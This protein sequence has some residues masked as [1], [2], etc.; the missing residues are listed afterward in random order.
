MLKIA[1]GIG[2]L[3]I[4]LYTGFTNFPLWIVP[5]LGL[6]SAAAY[7]HG[8]WY[9]WR[10]LFERRDAKFYQSLAVTYLIQNIVVF[11]FY[12]LGS[13]IGRLVGS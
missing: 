9:L 2:L 7:I 3:A 11:I 6:P 12:L 4:A 8:K 13:G 5:V 10:S 1:L